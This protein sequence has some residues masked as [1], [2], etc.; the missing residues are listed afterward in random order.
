MTRPGALESNKTLCGPFIA[1]IQESVFR[2][3]RTDLQ[4]EMRKMAVAGNRGVAN[5]TS[6]MGTP[7]NV[8]K[9]SQ[10]L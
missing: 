7:L 8:T 9:M 1:I 10:I 3:K 6:F 4:D 2:S 5:K